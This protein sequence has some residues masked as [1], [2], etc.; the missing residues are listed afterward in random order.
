MFPYHQTLQNYLEIGAKNC[1]TL[2]QISVL[3]H[4]FPTKGIEKLTDCQ[5]YVLQSGSHSGC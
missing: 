4:L 5:F 1:F 3:K 2:K